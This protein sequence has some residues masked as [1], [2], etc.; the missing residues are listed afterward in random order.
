MSQ[1]KH[2]AAGDSGNDGGPLDHQDNVQRTAGF[3]RRQQFPMPEPDDDD[4]FEDSGE[5][6]DDA[7]EDE[8]ASSQHLE[9]KEQMYQDKLANLK[10]QVQEV[11]HQT[12][13]E[14]MRR[15]RFLQDELEDRLV[16]NDCSQDYQ[17]S[18]AERDCILEKNAASKEYE[19]KKTELK[20]NVVN[21]LEDRKKMIEHEFST[22]E[23]NSDSI[24]VKPT[25]TRK[26]RR[27]P[28][29]PLP[30]PE[31][32][33]KPT[34]GQ[35]IF[36]LDDKEVENDLKLI[37]RGKPISGRLHQANGGAT[38]G[39]ASNSGASG[40]GGTGTSG[41][42]ISSS[43]TNSSGAG[44]S[45]SAASGSVS[46]SVV[47]RANESGMEQNGASSNDR[48]QSL[49]QSL[50]SA[51]YSSGQ[52]QSHQPLM[53]TRIE[54][55]KLLHERR[56]FHRGQPVFVEGKDLSRFSANISAIGSEAIWVKKTLD[57]Q[58]VRI[59]LSH[60]RRNKVSIK[61]RAN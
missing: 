59:F 7:T 57:G 26:L 5:G 42:N 9:I 1:S 3:T 14:Y 36:L 6:T 43:G 40:S 51:Q 38:S 13:A 24:D 31:K 18:C 45:H 52:Q 29:E 55:G 41:S 27:R 50:T 35:L 58:K 12:H 61:R 23:L 11:K 4:D 54:D 60:L 37:S 15:L 16:L 56:W 44:V 30:V 49:N 25:V 32:R 34:T 47:L 33:R 21:D 20:E 39:G 28:N 2:T 19:E 22:M 17:T 53:E 10:K 48:A 46:S 8:Y